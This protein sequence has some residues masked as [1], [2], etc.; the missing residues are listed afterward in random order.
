MC[1]LEP[2]CSESDAKHQIAH[3]LASFGLELSDI[4]PYLHN[5][6]SFTVEDDTFSK[7]T[8]DLIRRRTVETLKT[9]VMAEVGDQPLVL[10]LEDLH[11][12]DKATEE[13]LSELV[14]AMTGVPL[15]IVLVYRP[16]YVQSWVVQAIQTK[17]YANQVELEPLAVAQRTE[18]TQALLGAI[19]TEL[20]QFVVDKTDGNPLFVEELCRSLDE[21]GVLKQ[22]DGHYSL[23]TP[24]DAL[25][26]PTTLQGVL[27]ARIDRLPDVLKDVLQRAAVIGRVFTRT[28]L[29]HVADNSPT[30]EALLEQLEK[31]E[32][33]YPSS[34]AP[35]REYSFKHVLMQEAVYQTLLRPRRE[36]YHE[37]VGKAIE[38]L[39]P[40]RLE[41]SYEL[42]AYHYGRSGNPDKA[43]EYLDL[44]NQKAMR[45]NAMEEAKAYFDAAMMHLDT[46]PDTPLNQQR[47]V[48]LLVNQGVAMVQLL[49]M[50]EY[51]DLL[52]RYESV[53]LGLSTQ[54]EVLA[55]FRL[56]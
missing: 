26:I 38:V 49:R 14:E 51:H 35:Q 17:A 15:L 54:T 52:T 31:L 55:Y 37:Q 46:L 7:L 20:E 24:L 50:P 32:F 19:P 27:L 11:W 1:D 25:D 34:L 9:L 30:L 16:E 47:R 40:D 12:I 18:M 10:I 41:E 3:H 42:I 2:N 8:P 6:L 22:E 29:S 44:A 23:Y 39:Y 4:A 21:S 43:V 13:V 48:T 28:L 53:A 33:I 45:A 56:S 5:L 36:A